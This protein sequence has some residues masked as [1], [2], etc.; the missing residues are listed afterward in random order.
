[1]SDSDEEAPTGAVANV[2]GEVGDFGEWEEDD[3]EERAT[4][5][6]FSSATHASP[7]AA[8]QHASDAFGFDMRALYKQHSLDFYSAM[9]TLNY[10]RAVA[11]EL[12]GGDDGAAHPAHE[13][14]KRVEYF[15]LHLGHELLRLQRHRLR[16]GAEGSPRS[17]HGQTRGVAPRVLKPSERHVRNRNQF[18]LFLFFLIQTF[19]VEL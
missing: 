10:A 5:C 13:G 16:D 1:M 7:T 11:A 12:G 15:H 18:F 4:R 17:R 6:L 2:E 19:K 8:L 14:E 3:E 9:Q